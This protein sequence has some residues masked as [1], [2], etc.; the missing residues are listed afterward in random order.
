VSFSVGGEEGI[1]TNTRA[2]LTCVSSD[3]FACLVLPTEAVQHFSASLLA[4]DSIPGCYV[5]FLAH[6]AAAR[7]LPTTLRTSALTSL[8]RFLLLSPNLSSQHKQLVNDMLKDEAPEMKL[9]AF[10]VAS[11]LVVEAPNEYATVFGTI[12]ALLQDPDAKEKAYCVFADLLLQQVSA[13]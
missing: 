6:I 11:K 12:Q 3:C 13:T 5:S 8:G 2:T 10:D 1:H 4:G 9:A 7:E